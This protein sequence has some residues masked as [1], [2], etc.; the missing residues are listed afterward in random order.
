[1]SETKEK[2]EK[3]GGGVIHGINMLLV[4]EWFFSIHSC[5]HGNW[6][7]MSMVKNNVGSNNYV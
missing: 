6:I 1:M 3:E 5:H 2:E 7:I 4:L